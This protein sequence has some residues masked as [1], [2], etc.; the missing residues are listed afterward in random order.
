MSLTEKDVR[1]AAKLGA[2]ELSPEEV[3]RMQNEL[4]DILGYVAVISRVSSLGI[5]PTSH[6]HG[7]TNFFRDDVIRDPLPSE[8]LEEFAPDFAGG[9]FRVPKII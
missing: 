5:V 9:F 2:L 8:K 3:V 7:A 6:V 4:G 1:Y